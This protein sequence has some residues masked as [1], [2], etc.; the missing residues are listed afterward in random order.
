M[1]N[2]KQIEEIKDHLNNAQNPVFFFDNDQDGLCSFLLLQRFIGR[3]KG[4]PIKTSPSLTKDY[5]RKVEEFNS[6]Y[7]FI[8]DKPEVSEEFIEEVEKRNIPIVWI[9]HHETDLSKISGTSNYYNP[10]YADEK[11]NEPVTYMCYKITNKKEDMWLGVVGCISDNF[12][13]DFYGEFMENFPDLC[14]DSSDAFDIFYGSEIGKIA[15]ILGFALKDKI[16]N[17]VSMIKF[18]GTCRGPSDFLEENNKNKTMHRRFQ[19]IEKKYQKI[20][21][22]AKKS[23]TSNKLLFFR[24]EGDTS[25]S[26][27]IANGLKYLFPDKFIV[28]VYAK[29]FRVNVSGRGKNIKKVILKAID[30]LENA[31]GGGHENAVGAHLK[32]LMKSSFHKKR[33]RTFLA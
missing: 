11:S 32:H 30:G 21:A 23:A 3:G 1:L 20:I 7:I 6:D 14:K 28:V 19:E 17:V 2:T 15:R 27:D 8:L 13:P 18:I 10:L 31:T 29:G 33:I 24:Y 5:F 9:D 4:F 22:K 26:S 16:S 25:M 12:V